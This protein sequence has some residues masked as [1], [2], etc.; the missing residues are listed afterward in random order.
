MDKCEKKGWGGGAGL[1]LLKM[2][3]ATAFINNVTLMIF[4]W[5]QPLKTT[6]F[7]EYSLGRQEKHKRLCNYG[8]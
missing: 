5:Y 2:G 3:A 1:K 4:N 6:T 7:F 8:T